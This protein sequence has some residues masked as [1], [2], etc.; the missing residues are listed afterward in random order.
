MDVHLGRRHANVQPTGDLLIAEPAFDQFRGLPLTF[1]QRRNCEQSV[2]AVA[3]A[4]GMSDAAQQS[5]G[6]LAG[7]HLLTAVNFDDQP[8]EISQSAGATTSEVCARGDSM[9]VDA[10][11]LSPLPTPSKG[12]DKFRLSE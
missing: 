12:F 5:G 3:S 8:Y 10:C 9:L 6:D 1:R 11:Q 7:A 4:G 2:A